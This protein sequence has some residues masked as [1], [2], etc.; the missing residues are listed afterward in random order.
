M[1][2]IAIAAA[3]GAVLVAASAHAATV[4][5]YVSGSSAAKTFFQKDVQN[6]FGGT[7]SAPVAIYTYKDPSKTL[8]PDYS[9][10]SVLVA[11]NQGVSGL[12][13]GDTLN[14][15]YAAEL[16]SVWGVAATY[17]PTAAT[18]AHLAITGACAVS[19]TTSTG[20]T[21]YS[22]AGSN[23]NHVSDTDGGTSMVQAAGDLLVTDVEPALFTADNWPTANNDTTLIPAKLGAAPTAAQITT[24]TTAMQP[25]VGQL[26]S[27]IGHNIPGVADNT[28]VNL[29]TTSL[30]GILTGNYTTW[31]QVPEVG[32]NDAAGTPIFVCRRDHGS[33]TEIS[34]SITFTGNECNVAAT[35]AIAPQQA[36]GD[37]FENPSTSDMV[38]C[39]AGA[40]SVGAGTIGFRSATNPSSTAA[41]GKGNGPFAVFNIDGVEPNA[42]NA[43][44]GI[45]AFAY[46]AFAATTGAHPGVAA[47]VAAKLQAR[48]A[49]QAAL[50]TY[51]SFQEATASRVSYNA[52]FAGVSNANV[53][54]FVTTTGAGTKWNAISGVYPLQVGSNASTASGLVTD[55]TPAAFFTRS[56]NSCAAKINNNTN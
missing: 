45:Y 56:G 37:F 55:K 32:I 29:S 16:G 12:N 7:T 27:V 53:G 2:N 51:S 4:D 8:Q 15:H 1:K 44:A 6:F 34:A 3:V 26:F 31:N 39:V 42:H 49:S 38:N 54:T 36:T 9:V 19:G 43:A 24:A 47:N 5:V 22:C 21:N 20:V 23:F 25:L 40:N 28:R 48:S 41:D 10:I 13:T 46:E 52:T 17:S 33:G 14:V 50:G 30:R 11:N 35:Q 18:R